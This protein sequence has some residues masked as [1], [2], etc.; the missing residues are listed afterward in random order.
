MGWSLNN[1]PISESHRSVGTPDGNSTDIFP[2]QLI[3]LASIFPSSIDELPPNPP[4][5]PVLLDTGNNHNFSISERHLNA[6]AKFPISAFSF[7]KN[8]SVVTADGRYHDKPLYEADIWL[9]SYNLGLPPL[10]IDLDGGFT[11]YPDVNKNPGPILPLLGAR[12]MRTAGLKLIAD[13]HTLRFSLSHVGTVVPLIASFSGVTVVDLD[14]VDVHA[15]DL[16]SAVLELVTTDG[17]PRIVV[18]FMDDHF[19][20]STFLGLLI[21]L[22]KRLSKRP[23]ARLALAGLSSESTEVIATTRLHTLWDL[24]PSKEEAID[25]LSAS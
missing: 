1:L 24:Y 19:V 2:Y 6:W 20:D 17:P 5:F 18:N 15:A 21:Q 23:G 22:W 7:L 10:R 9:H 13:Y 16:T 14:S 3:A 11:F 8:S 25:A 12:A 4:K